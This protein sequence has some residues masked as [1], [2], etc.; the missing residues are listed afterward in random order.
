VPLLAL[1]GLGAADREVPL[2]EAVK[3]ADTV[4]VRA[5]LQQRVDVNTPEADGTTALH[6]AA[7]GDDLDTADLLIGA[8]ANVKAANRYGVTPL[9]LACTR[10]NA[11]MIERLLKAGADPNA[12]LADGETALMTAARTD[13]AAA[14]KV[15]LVH[16]ADVN[17]KERWRGQTALM[18]AAIENNAGIARV[19][20]EGGADVHAR[21]KGGFT[22][23]L[24]AARAGHLDAARVLLAAGANVNDTLP[25]GMSTVVLAVLNA[26]Y[27]FA[28]FLLE[29]GADPNA[30]AQGWTALHQL[31]WTRRPNKGY[32][33][34]GPVPTGTL[35]GLKLVETLVA[36][37]ANPNARQTKEPKDGYRNMLN[38]IG[39]T[40]FLLAAK[41]AD[42]DLMRALVANGVDP[43]M[44]TADHTT[45]LMAAAGVGIWNVGE[46]PG[47]NEE[48][49]EAVK[50]C[51]ELGGDATAVDDNGYTALHGAAH[52]GANE[53]V[54]L[55][56]GQGVKLD[57]KLTKAGGGSSGWQQ[58]WTPLTIADGVFYAA[59]FKRHLDTA[60]LLRRLLK[61]RGLSIDERAV[62]SGA[63]N[64]TGSRT[65]R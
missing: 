22:P 55:L 32:A 48:A 31:A 51:L 49:L 30:D 6:W 62:E 54:Q 27:E 38:R 63:A 35:D 7:H 46:S 5:L 13:T 52:R 50:L 33:N 65:P 47:T 64:P 36:H 4:A 53:M 24:F 1:F 20:I 45:P 28:A 37:G 17:A 43:L 57:V 8:G 44:P 11:A 60:A 61:E 34:P 59:S 25:D 18:W 12:A 10:G 19:L 29:K 15:L 2:A 58:G 40:P 3:K 39:A 21:S 42:V 23:V 16:G 41:S 56:V 14:A 9:A 26:H